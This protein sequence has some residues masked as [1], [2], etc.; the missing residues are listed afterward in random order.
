MN[1][2]RINDTPGPDTR[3]AVRDV[4]YFM[5]DAFYAIASADSVTASESA[6]LGAGH[7]LAMCADAL[8]EADEGNG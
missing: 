5:T 6:T 8:R 2:L 1:P 4:L 3:Q 7:I